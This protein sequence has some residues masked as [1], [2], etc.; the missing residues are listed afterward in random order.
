MQ[1]KQNNLRLA[2]KARE[3]ACSPAWGMRPGTARDTAHY[4]AV[5]ESAEAQA[6]LLPDDEPEFVPVWVPFRP[7]RVP[8]VVPARVEVQKKRR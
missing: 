5:A 4:L 8:D 2:A 3:M 1:G 7:V 6:A